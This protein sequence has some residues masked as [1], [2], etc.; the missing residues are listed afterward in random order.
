MLL[1]ATPVVTAVAC[2]AV[3][4]C[5]AAP[6]AV[7]ATV[8]VLTEMALVVAGAVVAL[9][10]VTVVADVAF[11]AVN[12]VLVASSGVVPLLEEDGV[13]LDELVDVAD[14]PLTVCVLVVVDPLTVVVLVA[15]ADVED[16]VREVLT[17]VDAKAPVAA[18]LGSAADTAT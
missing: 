3:V 7:R 18:A 8:C 5:V 11:W 6:A 2:A 4:A 13:T 10:A 16:E 15:A 12:A 14:A 17:A 9:L 1:V